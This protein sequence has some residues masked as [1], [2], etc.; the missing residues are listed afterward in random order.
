MDLSAL[1]MH[2]NKTF[3]V[4]LMDIKNEINR[5]MDRIEAKMDLLMNALKNK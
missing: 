4:I 5:R 3:D 1:K 2:E